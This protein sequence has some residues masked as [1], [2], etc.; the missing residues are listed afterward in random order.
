MVIVGDTA[1]P[2]AALCIETTR[3]LTTIDYPS[4]IPDDL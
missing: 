3:W 1:A 2:N 4:Q